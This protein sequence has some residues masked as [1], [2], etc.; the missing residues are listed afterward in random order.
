MKRR[1]KEDEEQKNMWS[2]K[3]RSIHDAANMFDS[4]WNK[5][6]PKE[7]K[8][9]ANDEGKI[10]KKVDSLNESMQDLIYQILYGEDD[11]R[12]KALEKLKRLYG[13]SKPIMKSMKDFYGDTIKAFKC[14]FT[15]QGYVNIRWY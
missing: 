10:T 9:D 2:R 15:G 13:K 7:N 3:G 12:E 4:S 14:F 6:F 1:R 11:Y 8:I 5:M